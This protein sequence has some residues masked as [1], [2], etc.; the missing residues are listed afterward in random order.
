MLASTFTKGAQLKVT[1]TKNYGVDKLK[2]L[3]YGQAG[4]GKTTLAR[5][6]DEPTLIISAEGGLLSLNDS[7]I[8]VIDIT[9]DDNGQI[10]P[11][12]KR[13]QRLGE[14]YKYIGQPEQIAKYKWIF[15]DSLTEISQ[16][17]IAQLGKEFPERKDSLVLYGENAK[18]LKS[19]IKSFRDM[20][21]YN[22]V[23]TA[24]PSL[25]KDENGARYHG[26]DVIGKVGIQ[27]PGYFDEVLYMSVKD[28]EEGDERVL[29]CTS[30]ERL[31]TKDRSG[32]LDKLEKPDLAYIASKIRGT[33]K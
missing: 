30:N 25:D 5:T 28:T 20:P 27:L 16:A 12:E 21:H 9:T 23:F 29:H 31:V 6:I 1:T 22:I 19:L 13:I 7:D 18:R 11:E 10:I 15:I 14:V 2:I 4:S 17:L 8:D 32:K 26:I 24:L 33:L 3:V